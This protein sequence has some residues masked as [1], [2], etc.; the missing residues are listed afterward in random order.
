VS[1]NA[2]FPQGLANACSDYATWLNLQNNI[3]STAPQCS[4]IM[5]NYFS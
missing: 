1:G 2:E 4:Y 3:T 5:V